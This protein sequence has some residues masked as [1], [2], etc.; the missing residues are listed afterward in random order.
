MHFQPL[1]PRF[2]ASFRTLREFEQLRAE[3]DLGRVTPMPFAL[4]TRE[5]DVLL[6]TMLPG[7]E[8][9]DLDL[10]VKD[11]T[12]TLSGRYRSEPEG[13]TALGEHVERPRGEFRRS[14]RAPFE[15]DEARVQA[16]LARGVLE[17][18]LPRLLKNPPVKIQVQS[19]GQDN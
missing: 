17:I 3:P 18:E 9:K 7:F 19:E 13:E 2:F 14:L 16:R 15:I 10:E 12:L 11:D 4:Y 1:G 8:A 5:G 6:R